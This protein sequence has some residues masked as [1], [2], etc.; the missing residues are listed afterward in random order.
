MSLTIR[1]PMLSTKSNLLSAR[2]KSPRTQR[3]SRERSWLIPSKMQSSKRET[4][5]PKRCWLLQANS[6]LSKPRKS[7]RRSCMR[8]PLR[9]YRLSMRM[10]SGLKRSNTR[11]RW[12]TSRLR[13]MSK[14]RGTKRWRR[15]I[16][17]QLSWFRVTVRMRSIK[18]RKRTTRISIKS[19]LAPETGDSI[20]HDVEDTLDAQEEGKDKSNK[21]KSKG[22]EY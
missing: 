1:R 10:I 11:R 16:E 17:R 4:N 13:L 19:R 7:K 20:S 22:S 6:N 8:R 14:W 3:M 9:S 15:E 2:S 12:S 5:T 18:S 21:T